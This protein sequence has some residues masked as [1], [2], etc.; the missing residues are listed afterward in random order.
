MNKKNVSK[1]NMFLAVLKTLGAYVGLINSFARLK[2]E[3]DLFKAKIDAI[4]DINTQLSEGTKGITNTVSELESRMIEAVVKLG[5]S[6]LTWAKDNNK[7]DLAEVFDVVK[8]DLSVIP[9]AD[10]YSKSDL[11]LSKV[12]ANDASLVDYNIVKKQIDDARLL[13]N[14]YKGKIGNVQSAVKGNKN[15]N[16]EL[17]KLFKETK[18]SLDKI[19]DLVVN[20]LAD[21]KFSNDL[22]AAK[23]I[24][25]AA[26]RSTGVNIMVTDEETDEPITTSWMY[27]E[28]SDKKDEADK[29]G[30][31][32]LYKLSPERIFFRVEAPGYIS[33]KI[34]A[35]IE[36]GK[37]I[38]LE[39]E[40]KK[41]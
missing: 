37:I 4:I 5:R 1:L 10:C 20:N 41:A 32:E 12:E 36:Q 22:I 25:D 16:K 33:E 30:M 39:V 35:T 29:D 34:E 27:L 13:V 18:E 19:I 14:E 17:N 28:G 26:V 8:T 9:D 23:V 3:V 2:Q 15:S 40:L 21:E 31:C 24:N 38:T 11:I 6:A 7:V